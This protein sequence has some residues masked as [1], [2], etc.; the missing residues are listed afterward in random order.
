MPKYLTQSNLKLERPA[1]SDQVEFLGYRFA[2]TRGV[3][4]LDPSDDLIREH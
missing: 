2:T 4:V 1:C 3:V